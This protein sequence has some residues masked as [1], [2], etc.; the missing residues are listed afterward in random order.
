MS[1]DYFQ[2]KQFTIKQDKCAMK[3]GTDGV[4]LGAWASVDKAE[5]ILDVGTGTGLIAIMLAQRSNA[6]IDA[7]E[8]DE[9]ASEQA[10]DNASTCPWSERITI[11]NKSFQEYFCKDV[12]KYDL[13][14]CN[15][16]YFSNSLKA[17]DERR[18]A[19][20]HDDNFP[21]EDFFLKCR[22]HLTGQGKL[23]IIFPFLDLKENTVLGKENGLLI[24]RKTIVFPV[25]HKKPVRCMVQFSKLCSV[26]QEDEIIIETFKRHNYTKE[27]KELTKDFY[28]A[29]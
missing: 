25:L 8:I 24:Y 11:Y 12:P 27:Y 10:F 23:A 19:A 29:F 6:Q 21:L 14:V 13:I 22:E 20:R 3:V 9:E 16:P 5:R 2:F 4:L 15:P 28:L 18:S 17:P 1:N 7:I 26:L